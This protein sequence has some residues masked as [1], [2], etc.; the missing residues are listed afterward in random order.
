MTYNVE[1]CKKNRLLSDHV[2]FSRC[3]LRFLKCL[4]LFAKSCEN[5]STFNK[6]FNAFF[7]FSHWQR[8]KT[9]KIAAQDDVV[10]DSVKKAEK[11]GYT[12]AFAPA[13]TIMFPVQNT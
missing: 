6:I 10:Q 5:I 8:M 12:S 1:I 2:T 9:E 3:Y 11:A 13:K 4:Y 7:S